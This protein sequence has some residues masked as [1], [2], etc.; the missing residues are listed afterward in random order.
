MGTMGDTDQPLWRRAAT[1]T[2]H[3][4][5]VLKAELEE[6]LQEETGLLLA[7]NE[8]L[9]NLSDGPLRMSDIARK[10]IL[11][12]G[13]TT[14]VIDRLEELGYVQRSPDPDDRRATIVDITAEGRRAMTAARTV[15]DAGLEEA[16]A[17]HLTDEEAEVLVAVMDRVVARHLED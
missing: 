6:R 16:W 14:K 3:A 1:H 12:R 4:A 13:G 17:Q 9:L 5:L 10:L 15:I 7:D 8:A 2:L 11:S